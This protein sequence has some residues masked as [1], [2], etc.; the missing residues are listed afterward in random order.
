MASAEIENGSENNL[1]ISFSSN[2]SHKSLSTELLEPRI[3]SNSLT[4]LQ[5]LLNW[6]NHTN[7][8]LTACLPASLPTLIDLPP[9]LLGMQPPFFLR[10][11][12]ISI[13]EPFLLSCHYLSSPVS[14]LFC[15]M[16]YIAVIENCCAVIEVKRTLFPTHVMSLLLGASFN[17]T[18]ATHATSLLLGDQFNTKL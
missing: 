3:Y 11:K 17:I 1:I 12:Y 10:A 8:C 16:A 6:S 15:M 2:T 4:K 13:H 5:N 18:F 7:F 14:Q 9:K